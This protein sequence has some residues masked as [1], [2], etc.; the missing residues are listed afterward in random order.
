ML[1]FS[2]GLHQVW[3]PESDT[4]ITAYRQNHL[5]NKYNQL[6]SLSQTN[7]WLDILGICTPRYF[8]AWT[9]SKCKDHRMIHL[10]CTSLRWDKNQFY[11][12]TLSRQFLVFIG[13]FMRG[14]GHWRNIAWLPA[15]TFQFITVLM[16]RAY[17]Q[18]YWTACKVFAVS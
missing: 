17:N 14:A 1:S 8:S 5:N 4:Q 7:A 18:A 2:V 13:W 16:A 11:V 9:I 3:L 6:P 15:F 12:P 10:R